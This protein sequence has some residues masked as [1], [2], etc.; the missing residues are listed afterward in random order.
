MK[1]ARKHFSLEVVNGRVFAVGSGEE[2]LVEMFDYQDEEWEVVEH[3]LPVDIKL[4][5]VVINSGIVGWGEL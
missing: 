1:E 2:G 5:P 3:F 4:S